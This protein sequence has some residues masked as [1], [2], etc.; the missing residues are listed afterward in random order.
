MPAGI[1]SVRG[2]HA[3]LPLALLVAA[4]S[5]GGDDGG[6]TPPVDYAS[7]Q[8]Q[9]AALHALWDSVTVS[10]PS[11]LPV[12]GGA[13]Y[14]GVIRLDAQ[15]GAGEVSM[16]GALELQ[17]SFASNSI[18]GTAQNFVDEADNPLAGVLTISNGAIDRG[19]DTAVEYTFSADL[20]GVLSG[21]GEVFDIT[22]DLS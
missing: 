17:A 4:C 21:G 18:A 11:T 2:F 13:T 15:L 10:D 6:T 16:A 12:S 3:L 5:D 7:Y 14:A 9:S 8:A 20:G 22:A 1:S 19:A